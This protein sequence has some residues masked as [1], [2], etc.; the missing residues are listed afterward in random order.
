MKL[1]V[2]VICRL[3][4]RFG[5]LRYKKRPPPA[6]CSSVTWF[7]SPVAVTELSTREPRDLACNTP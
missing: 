7:F 6:V 2:P 3:N 1:V 4:A 5:W